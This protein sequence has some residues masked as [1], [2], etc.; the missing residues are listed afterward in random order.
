MIVDAKGRAFPRPAYIDVEAF[1]RNMITIQSEQM[2]R[3]LVG[4]GVIPS[5]IVD[6]FGRPMQ[7]ATDRTK[8]GD[9]ISLP[10]P[11]RFRSEQ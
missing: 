10:R 11:A 1:M 9:T 6:Q 5:P 7:A 4:L 3:S 8:I 2:L